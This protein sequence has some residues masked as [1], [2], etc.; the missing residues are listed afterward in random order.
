MRSTVVLFLLAACNTTPEAP[1]T[2]GVK[3]LG[4]PISAT[5]TTSLTQIVATPDAYA[6]KEVV[7]EGLVRQ[8][9]QRKGC[10]MEVAISD[11]PDAPGCRVTFKD[12][13]FFVPKTSA[14]S[15]T[16]LEGVVEVRTIEKEHVKHYESEGAHVAAKMPD[17]SARE[18]TIVAKGVELAKAN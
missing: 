17:G 7:T 3:K 18:L 16:K 9:C 12:Y 13:G 6:G 5:A 1:A 2:P 11:A 15:R 10:W 14:G 8:A 4:E